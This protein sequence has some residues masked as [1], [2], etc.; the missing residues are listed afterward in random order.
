ML[1]LL[2]IFAPS[3]PRS[4]WDTFGR[5]KLAYEYIA[6]E[7]RDSRFLDNRSRLIGK[8]RTTSYDIYCPLSYLDITAPSNHYVGNS[9][10]F[11][12]RRYLLVVFV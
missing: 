8:D 9:T 2:R 6:I 12:L 10:Y 3:I 4:A 11:A 7:I 5:L 1:L